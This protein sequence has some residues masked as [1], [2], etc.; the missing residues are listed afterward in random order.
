MKRILIL[1]MI[2]VSADSFATGIGNVAS[3]PCDND[4]LS[5]Y[6]GTADVEINWEPNTIGLNWYDGDTKLTVD[7]SAQSCVYDGTLTVPAQPTKP[8]YT[9]NGWKVIRVPGGFTELEYLESTGTQYIDMNINVKANTLAEFEYQYTATNVSNYVFGQ[10]KGYGACCIGYRSSRMWWF[11]RAEELSSLIDAS[12]HKVEFKS[13]GN[14]YL[15]GSVITHR[16]N[17]CGY[18]QD[19]TI[20]L[21][22]ERNDDAINKGRV[23]IFNFI[24]KEGDIVVRNFIPARRDSDGVLGMYDSITNQFFTNAGTGTFVAGPVVQ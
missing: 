22:A 3:A 5:K 11:V 20:L 13:D 14:V 10:I 23:K 21:F 8:G 16:G 12:K 19:F 1:L 9:F 7:N 18:I 17:F 4:T 6:N 15:D 2:I 24:L